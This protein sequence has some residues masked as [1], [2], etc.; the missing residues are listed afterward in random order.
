MMR[1]ESPSAPYCKVCLLPHDEE[2]HQATLAIRKWHHWQVVKGF[3]VVEDDSEQREEFHE[4]R[5]A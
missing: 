4:P 1:H 3:E 5:V 2:I